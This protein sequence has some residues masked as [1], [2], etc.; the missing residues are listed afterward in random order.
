MSETAELVAAEAAPERRRGSWQH[1]QRAK[2]RWRRWLLWLNVAGLL[3]MS[4]WF[5]CRDLGNIPGINGDEAW[6][7][8]QAQ[9]WLHA[10]QVDWRTPTGNL[11]NPLFFWPQVALHSLFEPSFAVLRV[12]A[13]AS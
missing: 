13:V 3:A 7:G 10:G 5:R 1:L 11:L 8:V 9:N 2:P 12:T 4:V 6:Y